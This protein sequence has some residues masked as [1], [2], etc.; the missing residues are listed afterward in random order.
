MQLTLPN[1]DIQ[2]FLL[3]NR[4]DQTKAKVPKIDEM[5]YSFMSYEKDET[6]VVEG[7]LPSLNN[8][9]FGKLHSFLSLS[10]NGSKL[11]VFDR[12]NGIL[13]MQLFPK[14]TI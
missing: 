9:I 1:S 7:F 4:E 14:I 3:S 6:F 8:E 10:D 5:P 12:R 11:R 13:V 2:V